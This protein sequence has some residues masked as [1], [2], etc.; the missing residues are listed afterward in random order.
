MRDDAVLGRALPLDRGLGRRN[1]FLGKIP[2]IFWGRALRP[3][4]KWTILPSSPRLTPFGHFGVPQRKA[5]L[6]QLR[7]NSVYAEC[8]QVIHLQKHMCQ[9]NSAHMTRTTTTG[10]WAVERS[11][12][13]VGGTTGVPPPTW[14]DTII[15]GRQYRQT[16]MVRALSGGHGKPK[17]TR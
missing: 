15:M 16:G 8:L 11:M 7:N 6:Q 9:W 3:V 10:R 2:Q 4:G 1:R 14:T 12:S 17:S 5:R 13:L